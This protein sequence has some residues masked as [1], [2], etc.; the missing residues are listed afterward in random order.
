[1]TP[2]DRDIMARQLE[3]WLKTNPSADEQV[4]RVLPRMIRDGRIVY[5]GNGKVSLAGG[6]A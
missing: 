2:D 4:D 5:L 3:E 6:E 1:M